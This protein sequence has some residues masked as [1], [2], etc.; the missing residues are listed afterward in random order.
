MEVIDLIFAAALSG[1]RT[2]ETAEQSKPVPINYRLEPGTV[3]DPAEER[4]W[5]KWVGAD[6]SSFEDERDC[7]VFFQKELPDFGAMR[8]SSA[9]STDEGNDPWQ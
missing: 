5:R 2:A 4:D 9:C 3:K 7:P 8:V 1:M 6:F